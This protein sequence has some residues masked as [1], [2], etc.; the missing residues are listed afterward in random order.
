[1]Y[2]LSAY[3]T[4]GNKIIKVINTGKYLGINK[5]ML[6]QSF[7]YTLVL[8]L[9]WNCFLNNITSRSQQALILSSPSGAVDIFSALLCGWYSDFAVRNYSLHAYDEILINDFIRENVCYLLSLDSFQL[10]W[11][12]QYL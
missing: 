4:V 9:N 11:A 8:K 3:I 10:S 2:L 12:L 5:L 6:I 7:G 1:M